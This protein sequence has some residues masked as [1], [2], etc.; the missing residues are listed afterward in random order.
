MKRVAKA[1][2]TLGLVGFAAMSGQFAMAADDPDSDWYGGVGVGR[3]KAKIDDARIT[4][5]LQGVGLATTSIVDDNRDFGY[6]LFAGYRFNQYFALEGGYFNLGQFGF[7]S[8]T[9]PAGTL[10]GK[11][12]LQGF[13]LDAVGILPLSERF[14]AFGRVG[15][16]YARAKDDFNGTGGVVVLDSSPSKTAPSYKTGLGI[17]Y[18][19]NPNVGLRG[20]L[21]R[22][23]VNDAV[24]N[25]GDIDLL[26]VGLVFGFGEE[27][28]APKGRLASL[29]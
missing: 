4:S 25:K 28:P 18:D 17:Q 10:T 7:V 15:L 5:G 12:K 11:I 21:E 29:R 13:N 19:F 27:K 16:Q 1:V 3:S 14:S 22:Y 9:N 24:G 8:T 6:K 2:G 26:S 23:R 20:E